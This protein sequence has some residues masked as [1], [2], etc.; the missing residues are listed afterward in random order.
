[1]FRLRSPVMM[2]LVLN[3][4]LRNQINVSN[5]INLFWLRDMSFI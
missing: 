2:F 5:V 1:L 4:V 3:E